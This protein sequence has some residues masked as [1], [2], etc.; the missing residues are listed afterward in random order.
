MTHGCGFS[1]GCRIGE[2]FL[3]ERF[4]PA[5]LYVP[6]YAH[7]QM[8]R[9]TRVTEAAAAKATRTTRAENDRFDDFGGGAEERPPHD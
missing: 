4:V 8:K 2:V 6:Y 3:Q 5:E 1:G 7:L 9:K